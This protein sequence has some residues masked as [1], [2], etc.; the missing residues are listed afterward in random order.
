M[1]KTSEDYVEH[2]RVE[3]PVFNIELEK[4]EEEMK[5]TKSEKV[6]GPTA[7]VIEMLKVDGE[8]CLKLMTKIF[9]EVLFEK[10]LSVWMLSSSLPTSSQFCGD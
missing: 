9:N 1:W 7:V 6:N 10:K 2:A 3:G 5:H 8:H 4:A